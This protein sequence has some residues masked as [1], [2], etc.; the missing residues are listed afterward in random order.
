M[1]SKAFHRLTLVLAGLSLLSLLAPGLRAQPDGEASTATPIKHF[2]VIFQENVSFDHYFGTYPFAANPSGE[3][4]FQAKDD[5]PHVDNLLAAGLLTNNPN[6]VNPFRIDR[7][8]EVTCDQNHNYQDEQYVFHGG[9]MD[10]F[11]GVLPYK[12]PPTTPFSC[13]DGQLGPNSVMGYYDG[14]TVT[15]LWTD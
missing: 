1:L 14:N 13:N 2:V 3:P 9:L 11:T 10:R 6:G 4:A 5:T 15:A 8:I 12:N 7:S